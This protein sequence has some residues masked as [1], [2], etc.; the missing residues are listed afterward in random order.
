[1]VKRTILVAGAV[2]LAAGCNRTKQQSIPIESAA[3]ERRTIVVDAQATG[4]VEPINVVE[5]KSK[6]S[7][8]ITQMP[9][10]VG[11]T[12]KPGD[13][14]V[15]LDTRDVRNQYD[16]AN[17]DL[18]AAQARLEIAEA[19]RTRT[20]EL[21]NQRIIT[22]QE[23]EASNLEFAN[24]TSQVV[25]ARA[26]LDL[27]QQR[28]DEATVRA[29]VV[30]TVIE[31]PVS[32]GQVIASATGSA[33]GGT[34]IL[35]MADLNKVRVRA[36]VNETDIG[37]VRPGQQARVIVDAYPE[38]PFMGSVE[39]IEPQAVVQQSVT[40]FPVLVSVSN[41]DGLLMPGM[42]GEVSMIIDTRTDVLAV[43]SDAVRNMREASAV[44]PM[45]G[46]NP[47]SVQ[48]QLRSQMASLGRGG[49]G[50]DS[51]RAAQ[52]RV[53]Q[54]EVDLAPAQGGVQLP[55]VTEQQCAAV[56]QAF[57]K[58]PEARQQLDALRQRVMS[59]E[60]DRAA[61]RAESQKIYASIGVEGPVAMACQR[62]QMQ[63]GEA[64]AAPAVAQRVARRAAPQ[65]SGNGAAAD[66]TGSMQGMGGRSRTRPAVVFVAANGS[67]TPRLV[68]V[69][70]SDFDYTE[71]VSGLEE[72]AQ[73]A[74]L[75]S[76][77][78]QAQRQQQNERFRN[79]SQMPGMSRQQPAGGAGGR[80][81]GGGGR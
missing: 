77:A 17:A 64:T 4:T 23:L 79:M 65:A 8:Q 16:Q 38:R 41:V 42:N 26:S 28:L 21:F 7:G 55:E 14:L 18:R 40:M 60:L 48:A 69:G 56:R 53:A 22:S 32:L 44:A 76:A 54:G 3:V 15:Q 10:E 25:R 80:P 34:T 24:A 1:V 75:A 81:Q 73:V 78:L 71:V 43:P 12:V 47:D 61:M 39:K 20:Q 37:Q 50:G 67:Y 45:L 68:R 27:A 5:V 9:V 30:G 51:G 46:L 2:L 57:G 35:R 58:K 72:G 11:S 66:A 63:R 29:P 31:K 59:G 36:L 6:S 74:L 70:V 52:V 62:R 13:L 19:Q 33:S 49:A